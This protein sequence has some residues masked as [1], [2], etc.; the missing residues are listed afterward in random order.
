MLAGS[1]EKSD[2]E[3]VASPQWCYLETLR[4]IWQYRDTHITASLAGQAE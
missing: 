3:K 1:P 4:L 2:Y